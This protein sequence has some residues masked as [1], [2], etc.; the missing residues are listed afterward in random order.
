MVFNADNRFPGPYNPDLFPYFVFVLKTL[1]SDH[2]ARVVVL[3]GSAQVG[4][5]IT[6]EVFVGAN[7]DLDPGDFFYVLPTLDLAATWVRQKWKRFVLGSTSLSRAFPWESRSRDAT[8][9]LFHKERADGRG[10]LKITGANSPAGLA[11]QTYRRQV[12]DDL[13]K[14][15]NND[16]GD[17]EEQADKRSQSWG[18]WAKIFKISTPGLKGSC[19]ITK[20]YEESNQRV[21]QL[22]C[23]HCFHWHHLE[24]EN[25]KKSLYKEMD[26]ADAHFYC[27]EC[28]GVIEEHHKEWM[29]GEAIKRGDDA[30]HALNPKSDKEG[31]F[32]WCAYSYL[33]SW[34]YIASEYFR[35]LG[36][37]EKEQTFTNDTLGLPYEQKGEAPPWEEIKKRAES[38]H[39]HAGQ[40]PAGYPMITI[41]IDVQGDRIE[42]LVKAWASEKRRATVAHGVINGHIADPRSRQE[43]EFLLKRKWKNAQG[44]EY[45]ADMVAIDANYETND[46]KDWAKKH[47][48][49]ITVKGS[50]NY[51]APPMVLVREERNN[52]GKVKK[53]QTKHWMVGVSGLKGSLYKNLEKTD[54][55]ERGYC[56]FPKDLEEE[57]Y[58]QL[59]SEKRVLRTDKRTQRS[60]YSWIKLPGVRN[61]VLD[62][63]L[64]AE[65]AARRVGWHNMSDQTWESLLEERES[66]LR[67]VQMDLLEP[68]A[69]MSPQDNAQKRVSRSDK[70]A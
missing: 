39:Y 45:E 49:V 1:Q 46:V 64:Y 24:W 13:G 69:L 11:M 68:I 25:F 43:L 41:G 2:P 8:N 3:M 14:W 19:R 35:T 37:P 20:N 56:A 70:L 12:H 38:S 60:D 9:T 40:V 50:N 6:A 66:P 65:A 52:K 17:P 21:Y 55:F 61:E 34:A 23:P 36:D 42:W 29:L 18:D 44:R 57:Y 59:C 26:Y 53:Q 62:I 32:I 22:P 67:H 47:S 51:T 5:T 33:V 10:A 27:P 4:K 30:W 48:K 58:K 15:D 63:E 54:P 28:G 16:H 7:L 31:F